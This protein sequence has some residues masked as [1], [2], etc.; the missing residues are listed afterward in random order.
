MNNFVCTYFLSETFTCEGSS[1]GSLSLVSVDAEA[2]KTAT[3]W[4]GYQYVRKV[5]CPNTWQYKV[6]KQVT[7]NK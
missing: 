6:E 1:A 5:E 3:A 2:G 7:L 4:A